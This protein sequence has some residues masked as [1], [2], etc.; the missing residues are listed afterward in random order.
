LAAEANAGFIFKA[1]AKFCKI[2]PS[3]TKLQPN[4]AKEKAWISLDFLGGNERFQRVAPTP[5]AFFFFVRLRRIK[6]IALPYIAHAR[7]FPASG[8]AVVGG[9]AIGIIIKG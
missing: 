7:L 3:Q 5:Q 6:A 9:G 1:D 2:Q 4:I 8:A